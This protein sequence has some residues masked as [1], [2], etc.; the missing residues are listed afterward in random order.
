MAE[1]LA[2]LEEVN[3][4]ANGYQNRFGSQSVYEY[5][6]EPT[7]VGQVPQP[8]SELSA[9][10]TAQSRAKA[11]T[12]DQ[13]STHAERKATQ[14]P[15]KPAESTRDKSDNNTAKAAKRS[16]SPRVRY[17]PQYELDKGLQKLETLARAA[18]A[19][20]SAALDTCGP[21]WI[22]VRTSGI[23]SSTYSE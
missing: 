13:P 8:E 22:R 21:S 6:I 3:G 12:P 9:S 14:A 4:H 19:G 5:E 15:G 10:A 11:A 1:L 7:A 17:V 23:R 16:A 2:T 18:E 20:D